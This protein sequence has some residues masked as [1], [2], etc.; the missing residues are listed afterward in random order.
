MREDI[1]KKIEGYDTVT[2]DIEALK[3]YGYD[4][5]IDRGEVKQTIERLHPSTLRM[6]VVDI[7]E[8][9]Q[10]AKTLRLAPINGT[11]PPF[12]AGQYISLIVEIGN[13]RTTRAYS[14]SSPPHCTGYYDVTVRRVSEGFVSNYLLDEVNI[15]DEILASGPAGNFY[16]NPII[17]GKELIFIAG[18]SGITP[19]MSMIRDIVQRGLDRTVHLFYGN[20]T[21]DDIIFHD[22]LSKISS[23]NTRIRY[24]P[25]VEHPSKSWNEHEGYITREILLEKLKK[26]DGKTFFLCGPQGLYDFIETQLAPLNIPKKKIRREMYGQLSDVTRQSGWPADVAASREFEMRVEGKGVFKAKAG[27]SLLSSLERAGIVLPSLCRSGECS[28]CRAKLLSG[29]VYQLPGALV[30]KS[31]KIFGYIHTCAAYPLS[32]VE[33][34]CD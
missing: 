13:V 8:E 34:V 29:K 10:S 9:T 6:R 20:K 19:F 2:R 4:Y 18:G 11:L 21:D 16:Y 3:K 7:I 25:V 30:R 14:I 23:K 28:M 12:M 5:R 32:D 33:L 15:G 17:H 31:D 1:I 27:E 26:I 22:E 24:Y